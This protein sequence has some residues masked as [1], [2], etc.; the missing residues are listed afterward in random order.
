MSVE[1]SNIPIKQ[2]SDRGFG[3]V[4]AVVFFAL[5]IYPA[6]RGGSPLYVL[7]AL[8]LLLFGIAFFIPSV[9]RIPN[10]LWHKF[11]LL[12]GAIVAP[13]MLAV[14]YGI[15]IVPLGLA[16]HIAGKKLLDKEFDQNLESYWIKREKPPQPMKNQF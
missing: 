16:M 13:I 15:T 3:L 2:S 4:F 6:I 12:L 11:G 5:G 8:A 10:T 14:V 9:L 1:P 7:L